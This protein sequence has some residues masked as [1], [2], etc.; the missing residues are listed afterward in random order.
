MVDVVCE[1]GC[2]SRGLLPLSAELWQS[3]R[4]ECGGTAT[5]KA[6]RKPCCGVSYFSMCLS[7]CPRER[8][9]V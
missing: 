6:A 1:R 9:T 8:R 4:C 5:V 2:S 3:Y 7:H